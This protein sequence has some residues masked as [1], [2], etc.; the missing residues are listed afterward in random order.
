M[1]PF[2][3]A[4]QESRIEFQKQLRVLWSAAFQAALAG[5]KPALHKQMRFSFKMETMPRFEV[6]RI[7]CEKKTGSV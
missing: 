4:S 5:W 7:A 3:L 6:Y 2:G 1:E